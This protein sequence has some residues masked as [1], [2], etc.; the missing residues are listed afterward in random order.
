MKVP[1]GQLHGPSGRIQTADIYNIVQAYGGAN[2]PATG[3]AIKVAGPIAL[4]S[5]TTADSTGGG[6]FS[7]LNPENGTILIDEIIVD[8]TTPATAACSASFG[9]TATSG[10]TSSANLLD[11][12]D[13]H[14][15][16][17]TL[18]NITNKGTNGKTNGKVAA[19]NW[20][21]GSKASGA[22][23]GMVANAYIFYILA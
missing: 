3:R 4:N 15:A 2:N 5:G 9:T 1:K 20:V 11:T 8:V 13:V 6:L 22:S 21:T 14:T 19:G 18:D 17:V 12:Q 16:A 10:T 23:A 7:W